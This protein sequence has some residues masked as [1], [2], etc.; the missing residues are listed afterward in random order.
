MSAALHEWPGKRNFARFEHFEPHVMDKQ[1]KISVFQMDTAWENPAENCR[2]AAEWIDRETGEADLVVLPEMFATGF[3][4]NP[5]GIAQEMDGEVVTFMRDLAVRTGKA[6]ITSVAIRDHIRRTEPE[7]GYFNR[8]FFFTPDGVWLTYNKRHLFR[9]AGEHE[10]Y[11]GGTSRLIVHYKGFRICPMVCYD[12]RFPVYSRNRQDYDV[13][14]YV[15]S[16]PEVRRYP[17]ST[18]LRARAIENQAY[19]IGCN[20]CGADPGNTYSGDSVILDYLGMPIAEAMP[21]KEEM[22]SATISMDDLKA[23]RERFPAHR[24]ADNFTM[25]E[26]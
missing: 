11:E 21:S 17:W 22:I 14:V 26:E 9:M 24:D 7:T 3:S 19:V 10:V 18:L 1:L 6:I 13:L 5:A 12:L 8:L 4:M 16:W 25:I 2:R 20:R 15:A 23:F